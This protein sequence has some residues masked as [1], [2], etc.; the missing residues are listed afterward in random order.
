MG[1]EVGGA[2]RRRYRKAREQEERRW[3][4]LNGPVTVTRIQPD[5][6]EMDL[7]EW[8]EAT[9]EPLGTA[10]DGELPF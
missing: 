1:L 9:G 8:M 6:A 7:E 2:A 10:F 5:P 3:R 4:R